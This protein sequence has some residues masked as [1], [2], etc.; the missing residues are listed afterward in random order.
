MPPGPSTRRL[1]KN[2]DTGETAR[3]NF[4]HTHDLLPFPAVSS[5]TSWE[6]PCSAEH[7]GCAA[8][9]TVQPQGENCFLERVA[10]PL[11]GRGAHSAEGGGVGDSSVPS[12]STPAQRLPGVR[13]VGSCFC[14]VL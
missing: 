4:W 13:R 8:D 9:G 1:L 2:S 5:V 3:Y 10:P 6:I 11:E 12:H 7:T 14:R